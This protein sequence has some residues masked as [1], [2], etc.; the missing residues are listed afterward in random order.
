MLNFDKNLYRNISYL[1]CA[2]AYL[3]EI[4]ENI[5]QVTLL[6]TFSLEEVKVLC[7]YL[8]CY[9]AP[10]GYFLFEEGQQADHLILILSGGVNI[11]EKNGKTG[12]EDTIEFSVGATLG[13]S[14]L[15]DKQ[16]WNASCIT[17]APTDFAVLTRLALNEMLVNHARLGNKLLLALMQ[18]MAL[19]LR[20][21]PFELD[22]YMPIGALK[23][24]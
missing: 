19:R 20:H 10:R 2:G 13:E 7:H 9:A 1:G 18:K 15:V 3:D 14:A 5:D 8:H 22:L 24:I 17:I 21:S 16:P 6:Q 12:V 4:V 11:T 23:H